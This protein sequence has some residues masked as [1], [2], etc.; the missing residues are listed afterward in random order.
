MYQKLKQKFLILALL[1]FPFLSIA[2]KSEKKDGIKFGGA[3]RYNII[4]TNYEESSDK[5]DPKF[6]WD[7]WRLNMDGSISGIDLSFEYRFYP[8]SKVHFLKHGYFG[9]K[10]SDVVYTK[11]GVTQVPF[12]ILSYASHSYFFQAPYYVGLEDDYDM[13]IKFDITPTDDI[14]ISLAYFRQAE[15]NGSG[16]AFTS[17]YS[18]DIVPGP[19][20]SVDGDGNFKQAYASLSELNQF[21]ARVAWRF[22]PYWEVGLSGQVGGI[23][24]SVLNESETSGAF[25]AHAVGNFGNFNLKT[26]FVHYNYRARDDAGNR[27]DVLQMGAYGGN[28]PG[29]TPKDEDTGIVDFTGCVATKANMYAISLAYDIPVNWGPIS[30][31]KPYVDYTYV[32]KANEHFYDTQHLIPG[33]MVTAGPIFAYFDYAMGKNQPWFTDDFGKGLG[34]GIEDAPWNSRLNINIGYYF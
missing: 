13:G 11:L 4:S 9:Y 23:Y 25:A 12:G 34:S 22:N 29:A 27:L 6:T 17:R 19:A 15:P 18:Y 33:F 3:L 10:F 2:Q 5:T 7:T 32:D 28:Y 31:I 21:N 16:P 8:S 14:D 24:N 26:E 30:S 1:F 20:A